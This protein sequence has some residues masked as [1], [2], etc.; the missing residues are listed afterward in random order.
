MLQFAQCFGML[1]VCGIT[2]KDASLSFKWTAKRTLYSMLFLV[3]SA[4]HTVFQMV[5]MFRRQQMEFAQFG[6]C[7]REKFLLFI[8]SILKM[9][10]YS[11][12]IVF[13]RYCYNC[14]YFYRCCNKMAQFDEEVDR[15]G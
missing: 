5:K 3:L 7:K 11:D 13:R 14:G 15:S 4:S 6:N 12:S 2:S 9:S 1:P 10:F 8:Q